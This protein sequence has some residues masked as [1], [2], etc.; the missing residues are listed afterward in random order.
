MRAVMTSVD[1]RDSLG[2]AELVLRELIGRRG[3]TARPL[4]R[5]AEEA[6]WDDTFAFAAGFIPARAGTAAFAV[7]GFRPLPAGPLFVDCAGL[8]RTP[9]AGACAEPSANGAKTSTPIRRIDKNRPRQ[10]IFKRQR[11]FNRPPS[12]FYFAARCE[13]IARAC[14]HRS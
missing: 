3:V 9:F 7:P 5:G 6:L 11:S 2:A 1:S 10:G 13:A 12:G 14:T 4:P 8:A